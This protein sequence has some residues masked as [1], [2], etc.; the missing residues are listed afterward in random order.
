MASA[1]FRR[2]HASA[3]VQWVGNLWE[4]CYREEHVRLFGVSSLG[5]AT[6]L[7]PVSTLEKFAKDYDSEL[8]FPI[9][10]ERARVEI[11]GYLRLQQ[12]LVWMLWR[13]GSLSD[14]SMSRRF[15]AMNRSRTLPLIV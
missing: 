13:I 14:F 15:C 1:R 6:F 8:K 2:L 12:H 10:T 9:K 7:G 5:S 11:F 4:S 3:C